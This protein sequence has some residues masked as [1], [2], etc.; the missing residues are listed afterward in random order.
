MV[1]CGWASVWGLYWLMKWCTS[2]LLIRAAGLASHAAKKKKALISTGG[3]YMG[4]LSWPSL[5]KLVNPNR[6]SLLIS[7]RSQETSCWVR[8]ASACIGHSSVG[9]NQEGLTP[10]TIRHLTHRWGGYCPKKCYFLVRA[11]KENRKIHHHEVSQPPRHWSKIVTKIT[12][13]N[14]G[15]GLP[16]R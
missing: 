15:R 4:S 10:S 16:P 7:W 8:R 3:G 11:Q 9:T 13:L 5:G 14:L 2:G 1:H 12:R 6:D